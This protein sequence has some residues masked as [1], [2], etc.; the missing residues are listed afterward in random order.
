[1]ALP[2]EA[3][4][5][6]EGEAAEELFAQLETVCL[7]EEADRRIAVAQTLAEKVGLNIDDRATRGVG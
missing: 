1:M 6:L 4:P 5:V 2:I 7:Q 3:T